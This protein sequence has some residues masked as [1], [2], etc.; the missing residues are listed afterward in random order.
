MKTVP[1]SRPAPARV[2]D[3]GLTVGGR[4]QGKRAA[5]VTFSAYPGDPRPRRAVEAL[6]GEGLVVDLIC[7]AEGNPQRKEI[8]GG[9]TV[10]R[11]PME[12]TR[13]GKLRYAFNYTVFLLLAAL[14]MTMRLVRGRYHL[15]HVH[16][17]PDVLVFS[18]LVPR[19]LG[20][21]VILDQHDPMPELMTTIYGVPPGSAAVRIITWLERL[22]LRYA[23]AVVT[24]NEACRKIF[25]ARSCPAE[26]ITV[27]MNS[28]DERIFPYLP[29]QGARG[30]ARNDGK[31]V[32]MYH[33][34]LVERN[35]L[36]LAV[37]ALGLARERIPG[38]ELRVFGRTTPYLDQVLAEARR[39]GLEDCVHHLGPRRLEELPG[40]IAACDV[41]VIPNQRN[42]FTDINTPTRLFEYLAVGKPVIAPRTQGITDYF[43]PDGLIYFEP[44]NAEDLAAQMERVYR[45]PEEAA[46]SAEA[47]QEVL[48][49][50]T[51]T[52]ER[53][54][55]VNL[56]GALLGR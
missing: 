11:V 24:V 52:R 36:E 8:N 53:E 26:K 31:F 29:A 23:D 40:E 49:E 32:M 44:S 54:V 10:Y 7:L 48:Q 51:W 20:A 12:H 4:F 21:K 19:L 28:P 5:M 38:A 39:L 42:A 50:H 22:S 56:A 25:S 30:A 16:N 9:L 27:V 37:V 13:G 2:Q 41:G 6:L 45:N 46:R 18:A 17:M 14:R 35:G 1:E 34:S 55:L 15:V 3:G 43:P 47:G 33:G